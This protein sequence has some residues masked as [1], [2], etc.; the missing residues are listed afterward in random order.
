MD[1]TVIF[2]VSDLSN[3]VVVNTYS[4]GTKAIDHNLYVYDGFIYEA[5]YRSGIHVFCAADPENPVHVGF[6]DTYPENDGSG[7]D[8]AWSVYPF[9]GDG[10]VL[11]SDMNR[12][13][14]V[15][16]VTDAL[17]VLPECQGGEGIPGDVDGDG[18]V[19]ILDFLDLLAAWGP[20]PEPCPPSCSAD[21][22]NDC[23]VGIT[24]LLIL[25]A[26]WS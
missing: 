10:I 2:D 19:G 9:F 26:N 25:L 22:D 16:D 3:P 6:F 1:E 17:N 5:Q 8:G 20:C 15:I 13:L 14:F 24:D 23:Q 4:V 18:T 21:F 7:F 11:I 12:G